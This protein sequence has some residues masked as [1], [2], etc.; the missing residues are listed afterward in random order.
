VKIKRFGQGVSYL[1]ENLFP[2]PPIFSL[3]QEHGAVP[4]DE[5]YSVFN[6]GHRL[7]ICVPP[8]VAQETVACA[9]QFGIAAQVIGQVN[10]SK[11]GNEVVIVS[12]YGE[13]RY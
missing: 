12:P 2:T 9:S 1:K 13:F 8:D 4:W 11:S 10:S 3:I 6:M 7:E 5:M